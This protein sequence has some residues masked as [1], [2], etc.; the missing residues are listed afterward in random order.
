MR[1]WVMK[2]RQAQSFL[3]A[4]SASR[5]FQFSPVGAMV[6]LR[7]PKGGVSDA[8][9]AQEASPGQAVFDVVQVNDTFPSRF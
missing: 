5:L 7:S 8:A 6:M 2:D 9:V 1:P 3:H 4:M